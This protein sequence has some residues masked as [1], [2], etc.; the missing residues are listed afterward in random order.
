[1]PKL[2]KYALIIA[3]VILLAVT[4]FGAAQT[5]VTEGS[6]F[7]RFAE[8]KPIDFVK[9]FYVGPAAGANKVALSKQ[10]KIT[11]IYSAILDYDF[12]NIVPAFGGQGGHTRSQLFPLKGV[13]VGD[14]CIVGST[15]SPFDGGTAQ[16]LEFRAYP[17][18]VDQV[19]IEA[20]LQVNDAGSYDPPDA[21][22][23][24]TC[25]SSQTP[26]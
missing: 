22:Y 26:Q 15:R 25:F 10:N 3:S 24:V 12:P 4:A 1:M 21:G 7:D 13:Q 16:D 17:W 19:E 5:L 11:G 23:K 9:G 6:N 14:P 2:N 8:F 20:I 18:V